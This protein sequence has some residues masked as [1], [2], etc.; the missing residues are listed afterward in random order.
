MTTAD[1]ICDM[2]DMAEDELYIF[3]APVVLINIVGG[4]G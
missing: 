2:A 4:K 3:L 1:G